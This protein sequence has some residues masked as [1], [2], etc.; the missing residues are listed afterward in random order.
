MFHELQLQYKFS[1]KNERYDKDKKF[2]V[3]EVRVYVIG[4]VFR[5]SI[6]DPSTINA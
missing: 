5:V 1:W 6:V 2:S 4:D 3:T